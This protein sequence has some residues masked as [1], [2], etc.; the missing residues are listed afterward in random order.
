MR[1]PDKCIK[2]FQVLYKRAFGIEISDEE[3]QT[4]GLAVMRL[5]A[6]K[7]KREL[8]EGNG[9]CADSVDA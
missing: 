6:I 7:K 1:L 3:A 5:V 4:Q 9:E 8:L 2:E